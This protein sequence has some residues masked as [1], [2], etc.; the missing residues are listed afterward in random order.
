MGKKKQA[1]EAILIYNKIYFQPKVIQ[2]DGEG[3]FVLIRGK[4]NQDDMSI[5]S[6]YALKERQVHW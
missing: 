4:I 6:A 5:L 1:G 3:N 2:K